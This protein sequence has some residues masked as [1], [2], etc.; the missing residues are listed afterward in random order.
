MRV[1][2]IRLSSKKS[3]DRLE[4]NL[5]RKEAQKT[6]YKVKNE[7]SKTKKVRCIHVWVI[8]KQTRRP[9]NYLVPLEHKIRINSVSI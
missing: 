6:V 8:Q 2:K 4:Y 7:A 3:E 5:S 1:T 9:G